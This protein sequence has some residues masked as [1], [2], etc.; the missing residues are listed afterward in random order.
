MFDHLFGFINMSSLNVLP[1]YI[2]EFFQEY[3]IYENELLK[4]RKLEN[5]RKTTINKILHKF[6]NYDDKSEMEYYFTSVKDSI[7]ELNTEYKLEKQKFDLLE[8]TI[9]EKMDIYKKLFNES[10]LQMVYKRKFFCDG[11]WYHIYTG[12]YVTRISKQNSRKRMVGYRV[13]YGIDEFTLGK[14]ITKYIGQ[15]KDGKQHGRGYQYYTEVPEMKWTDDMIE[16]SIG[17][18]KS[19][20]PWYIGAWEDDKIYGHGVLYRIDNTPLYK[21]YFHANWNIN[22]IDHINSLVKNRN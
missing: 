2:I 18:V 17:D 9:N 3:G 1:R 22:G 20:K 4:I 8:T 21:G 19:N 13:I 5:E 12:F 14:N 11:P 6:Y 7:L 10:D 16:L 15:Y